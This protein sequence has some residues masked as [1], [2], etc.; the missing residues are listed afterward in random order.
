[1]FEKLLHIVITGKERSGLDIWP[2]TFNLGTGIENM[3][4]TT[5]YKKVMK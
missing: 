3:I 4:F 1:M 5:W 2:E